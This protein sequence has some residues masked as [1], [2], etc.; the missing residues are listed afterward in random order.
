VLFE[1]TEAPNEGEVMLL[2]W[3]KRIRR[4]SSLLSALGARQG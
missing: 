4:S 3:R 1:D 2:K